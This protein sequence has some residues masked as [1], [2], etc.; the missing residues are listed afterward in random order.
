M[1]YARHRFVFQGR[2]QPLSE[3]LAD[4][5]VKRAMQD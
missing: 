3:L 5:Q 1:K 4:E 2:A